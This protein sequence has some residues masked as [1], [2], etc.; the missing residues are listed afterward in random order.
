MTATFAFAQATCTANGV[1]E[2]AGASGI[3]NNF[4]DTQLEA[5]LD[6]L[7]LG[8]WYS[9]EFSHYKEN[10][11]YSGNMPIGIRTTCYYE[12]QRYSNSEPEIEFRYCPPSAAMA[13]I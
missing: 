7:P 3:S 13:Q 1:Q 12:V 5:C 4:F 10:Y 11:T 6:G 9:Q 8:V 2:F